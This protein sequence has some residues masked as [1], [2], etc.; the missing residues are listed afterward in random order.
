MT[1]FSL[2]SAL[3]ASVACVL[4][5]GV[6]YAQ[7]PPPPLKSPEVHPD[8]RVTFRLRAPGAKEVA[9]SLEGAERQPM[10]RDDQG[11]WSLTTPALT[12]DYYGYSFAVDGVTFTDPSHFAVKPN[13]I[14]RASE[15]H[16]PGDATLPWEVGT[17]PRGRLHR[18]FH[19]STIVGDHRDFY[20]Y[21]PPGYDGTGHDRYPVLYL[22]H[23]YS[24]DASG[25][26]AV[27]RAHVIL[28]NL[29]ARGE[30]KPMLV[31]MPLGYGAPEILSIGLGSPRTPDLFQRNLDRFREVLLQEV[32]PE[33]ERSYRIEK[34]RDSRAIAGLSMGGGQALDIGLKGLDTFAWIGAFSSAV[35]RDFSP[36]LS[37]APRLL[38]IACGTS[39]GLI[40]ANRSVHAALQ[41]KK[42]VHTWTEIPGAG[43]TWMLWRRNLAAFAAL[44]FRPERPK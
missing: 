30:A 2:C 35:P 17:A 5:A 21:T 1:S 44:L 10:Q 20:V 25:W 12:P 31:V 27:G 14:W 26:T 38:W 6:A 9:F 29:I 7:Q 40:E 24:D 41:Q 19:R 23:G 33:V 15:V 13:F 36:A 42:V 18:H 4:T 37:R 22:L 43:H 32:M 34:A 39:D 11:V 16:V 3:A 28:D 8:G